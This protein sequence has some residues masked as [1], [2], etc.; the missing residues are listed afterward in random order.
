[1]AGTMTL[2]DRVSRPETCPLTWG[3]VERTTGFEPAT[4]TLA[5]WS[6]LGHRRA[7]GVWAGR[8]VPSGYAW[9]PQCGTTNGTIDIPT[10][11]VI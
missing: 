7:P 1:M 6:K 4:L 2:A 5:N 3:F 9:V 8:M 10:I 11:V